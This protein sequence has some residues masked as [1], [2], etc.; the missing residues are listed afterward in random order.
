M[1]VT[2]NIAAIVLQLISQVVTVM[3]AQAGV[4]D[5]RVAGFL[6]IAAWILTLII[7]ANNKK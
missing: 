5:T 1:T 7:I 4:L 6:L 2:R 3:A